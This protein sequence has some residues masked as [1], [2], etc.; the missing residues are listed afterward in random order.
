MVQSVFFFLNNLQH[1]FIFLIKNSWL[2]IGGVTPRNYLHPKDVEPWI[3]KGVYLQNQGQPFRVAIYMLNCYLFIYFVR[4]NF[5]LGLMEILWSLERATV[6]E[7]N[8]NVTSY[9][10]IKKLKVYF[11]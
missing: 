10:G 7:G 5:G 2:F 3:L 9:L 6:R 4:F 1:P 11:Y 8:V